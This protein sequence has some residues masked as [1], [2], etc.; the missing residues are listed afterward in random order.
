MA[1]IILTLACVGL[2]LYRIYKYMFSRPKN[3]PPGPPRIPFLG[4]YPLMLLLNYNHM[5]LA[6]DWLCE[7]YETDL[8]GMYCGNV[9]TIVA[10]S[11]ASVKA[12]LNHSDFDGKPS[13]LLGKLRH[14]DFNIR[15]SRWNSRPYIMWLF[16]NCRFVGIFF[17]EGAAWHEQ[18][19][20]MLRYLR[21]FGFGRRF[22]ELETVINDEITNFID[23]LKNGPKYEHENVSLECFNENTVWMEI[24]TIF[25]KHLHRNIWKM[26]TS[27]APPYLLQ[28]LEIVSPKYCSTSDC[29]VKSN[30]FFM[31]MDLLEGLIDIVHVL[32]RIWVTQ[33]FSI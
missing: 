5:H 26:V 14:L 7:Y 22:D 21:D 1:S 3:F 12:L 18:R 28:S 27:C 30:K 4:S 33:F 10:H 25:I 20:F 6:V 8:L 15:G 9:P 31:S 17:T 23:M 19:R 24:L 2:V 11:H 13:L 29:H 16:F 32:N